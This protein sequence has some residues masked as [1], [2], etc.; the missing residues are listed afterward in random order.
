M[1]NRDKPHGGDSRGLWNS[2]VVLTA[3]PFNLPRAVLLLSLP[4][5]AA[6]DNGLGQGRVDTFLLEN[7]TA[8][9]L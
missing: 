5:A 7:E 2:G 4:T 3:P 8:P 1:P 6:I 9:P